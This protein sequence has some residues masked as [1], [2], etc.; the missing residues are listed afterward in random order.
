MTALYALVGSVSGEL[1]THGGKV[2]VHGDR[3]EAEA[4]LVGARVIPFPPSIPVEDTMRLRDHP[5]LA[6]L[7]WPLE[8][9]DLR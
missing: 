6:H 9:R 2:L 7:R 5:G 3:A 1:L 4:L 8:R